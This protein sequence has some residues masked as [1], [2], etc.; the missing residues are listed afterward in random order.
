MRTQEPP[1]ILKKA[2]DTLPDMLAY[3]NLPVS[4]ETHAVT[5]IEAG[6]DNVSH[7]EFLKRLLSTEVAAK[8]ERQVQSRL[9]GARFPRIKTLDSFD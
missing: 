4:L 5:L 7:E 9:R 8:F 6:K 3:L 2:P 1:V